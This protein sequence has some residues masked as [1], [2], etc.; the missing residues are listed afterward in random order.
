MIN[1]KSSFSKIALKRHKCNNTKNN[2]FLQ[3][4]KN[5]KSFEKL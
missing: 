3:Q 2:I 1:K 5:G 4:S